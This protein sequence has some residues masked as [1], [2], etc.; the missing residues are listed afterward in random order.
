MTSSNTGTVGG[1]AFVPRADVSVVVPTDARHMADWGREDAAGSAE[2]AYVRGLALLQHG[3]TVEAFPMLT[4]ADERGSAEAPFLVAEILAAQGDQEAARTAL[5]RA[6]ERGSVWAPFLHYVMAC[7]VRDD[8]LRRRSK[9]A[10]ASRA[11]AADEAGSA[12]GAYVLSA[13]TLLDDDVE[14]ALRLVRRAD[15]RGSLNAAWLRAQLAARLDYLPE[16]A[17]AAERSARRGSAPAALLL[18]D[19]LDRRR[20]FWRAR[21]AWRA[22][23]TL[24]VRQG[25][26]DTGDAASQR[27]HPGAARWVWSHPLVVG[28]VLVAVVVLLLLGR[29]PWLVA[30]AGWA[31]LVVIAR[32]RRR[33]GMQ[34]AVSD[35]D[36]GGLPTLSAGDLTLGG[37]L[38]GHDISPRAVDERIAPAKRP[39][40][41]RDRSYLRLLAVLVGLLAAALTGWAAGLFAGSAMLRLFF[42]WLAIVTLWQT[43][44]RAPDV[45]GW[46]PQEE[47]EQPEP[48]GVI[49][50]VHIGLGQFFGVGFRLALTEPRIHDIVELVRENSVEDGP[51]TRGLHRLSPWLSALGML[52]TAAFFAAEAVVA[53]HAALAGAALAVVAT[54]VLGVALLLAV[55]QLLRGL[56]RP[57]WGSVLI[58]VGRLAVI[59]LVVLVSYWLG[60]LDGWVSAWE[61]ILSLP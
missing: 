4:R 52:L 7:Q 16:A 54:G 18:G 55:E 15:E 24:A 48:E 59:G 17:E 2:A 23:R 58:A 10:A 11:R 33:L 41:H 40:T 47:K 8:E 61:R 49:V 31:A 57:A 5:D 22:A 36:M 38:I 28:G 6:D 19:L 32:T 53:E 44:W 42:L 34:V 30:A 9:A 13:L 35:D 20:Q 1:P 43:A 25:D 21:T 27:L 56:F 45:L 51:L 39:A 3:A 14:S 26:T 12:D 50:A 60:L 37:G 29:W 46:T